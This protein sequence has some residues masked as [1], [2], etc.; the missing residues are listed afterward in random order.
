MKNTNF[1]LTAIFT[2]MVLF[3]S[4]TKETDEILS[5][6]QISDNTEIV[7]KTLS[8]SENFES[9]TKTGYAVGNVTLSTGSWTLDNA[10]LGTS[11]SDRKNGTKSVRMTATAKLTMLFDK[12]AGAGNVTVYHAL[13][14]T[15][16]TSTWELWMSVNQGTVWTKVGST[17]TT[18]STT[19]TAQNFTVNQSGNV[20]FEIRKISGTGRINIDDFSF[21]DYSSAPVPTLTVSSTSLS[22]AAAANSTSTFAITSNISWTATSSQT[23]LTLN[24]STGTGNATITVTAA[25]NTTTNTRTANVTVSGTDVTTQ[26]VTVTQAAG[27]SVSTIKILFDAK[28]AQSA[29]NADWVIDANLFNLG[30]GSSGA[31]L[32]GGSE[33]NAQQIP[34]P[35]QSGITSST[36]ET[37]WK[38]G[39]SAWAVDC[40]K[41]GYIVE[42]L[43]YNGQITYGNSSNT[44]DLSNYKIFIT[45]EPNMSFTS[46]EKTAIITFVQNGGSL[47]IIADHNVSDRNND[48]VDSPHALN[49]LMSSNSI[50][51]N[52]F[53]ITF[54]YDNFSVTTTYVSTSTTDP[55]LHGIFGNVTKAKWSSGCSMTINTTANSSVKG[56]V[57]KTSAR[58]NTS[59][60]VAYSTFGSGKV[61]AIG[62]SSV[63]DDG[64]GDTGDTLYNGY[65][66]DVSGNH[67]LLLMNAITWLVN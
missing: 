35:A 59:V 46:S 2:A 24:T 36:S 17:V 38:G 37:Y 5:T 9:G 19:L 39:I 30:W 60:M 64:T 21:T 6:S 47:I 34:T 13:Y 8:M 42:T 1:I 49:D 33:S 29:G 45:C 50:Q 4:C 31:T 14:G 28:K 67:R 23:W 53:G 44:Q 48:G 11:S 10:L 18:S 22:V 7:L 43:P 16:A 27:N 63:A 66:L 54:N 57:F 61:V 15:D 26:T 3:F 32:N 62:D 40:A 41:K 52:P 25:Q 20:R 56:C 51:T 65:S 55:L 12:T 58:S